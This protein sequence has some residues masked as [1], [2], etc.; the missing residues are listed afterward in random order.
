MGIYQTIFLLDG[1]MNFVFRG[2]EKT[3]FCLFFFLN[4]FLF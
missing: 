3:V 2:V 1:L 4:L